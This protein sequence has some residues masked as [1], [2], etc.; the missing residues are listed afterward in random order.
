MVTGLKALGTKLDFKFWPNR[1]DK[2][3]ATF[4]QSPCPYGN[5]NPLSIHSWVTKCKNLHNCSLKNWHH[6]CSKLKLFHRFVP[7]CRRCNWNIFS[8]ILSLPYPPVASSIVVGS[9]KHVLVSSSVAFELDSCSLF[10]PVCCSLLVYVCC[11]LFSPQMGSDDDKKKKEKFTTVY[12][13]RREQ[14]YRLLPEWNNFTDFC[15]LC[16]HSIFR[17]SCFYK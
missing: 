13:I 3:C 12:K 2:H 7:P 1:F 14:L 6:L 8:S 10:I 4:L 5:H 17:N 9:L 15:P 11:Y 16:W